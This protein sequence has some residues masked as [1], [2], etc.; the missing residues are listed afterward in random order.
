MDTH[1]QSSPLP[2]LRNEHTRV[3]AELTTL[4]CA[5]WLLELRQ[6]D[7]RQQLAH[8]RLRRASLGRQYRRL[9]P[10]QDETR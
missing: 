9:L 5:I 3:M 1:I 8:H 7:V 4:Q 6:A 10:A 2:G